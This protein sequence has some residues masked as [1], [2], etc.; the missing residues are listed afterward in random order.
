VTAI[1]LAD[2]GQHMDAGATTYAVGPRVT[3]PAAVYLDRAEAEAAADELGGTY[4][5]WIGHTGRQ[6]VT[7][8]F[9]AEVDLGPG[10]GTELEPEAGT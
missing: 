5:E 6:V 1:A 7:A 8:E 3:V 9:A 4:I 10:P 2:W